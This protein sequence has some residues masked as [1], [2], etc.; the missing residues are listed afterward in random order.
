M[1]TS[2]GHMHH[3]NPLEIQMPCTKSLVRRNIL[4]VLHKVQNKS[5]AFDDKVAND[6]VDHYIDI[7]QR[8][9]QEISTAVTLKVQVY[10]SSHIALHPIE[11]P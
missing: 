1:P 9:P 2:F 8:T 11:Y 7:V 5:C 10:K 6:Y 4:E 3:H